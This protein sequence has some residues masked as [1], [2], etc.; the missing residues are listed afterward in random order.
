MKKLFLT[1]IGMMIFI[2]M[3]AQTNFRSITYEEGLNAAKGE[4]KLLFVDFYTT[5]CGPCKMMM[6]NVFPTK[7][8]GDYFNTN[9][10]C[11]K[12]DAEAEGK[13]LAK[14]LGVNAYPTFFVLDAT[15]NVVFK[16]VGGDADALSFIAAIKQGVN[17]ELSP[18]RMAERYASGERSAELIE[19][20]ANSLYKASREGRTIDN[21]KIEQAQKMVNDY[22]NSLTIEQKLAKENLFIYGMNYTSS[23]TD[24]KAIFMFE[25]K[26]KFVLESQ[27]VIVK[28]IK[29]L[30][31]SELR[32]Y[33][34]GDKEY[35]QTGFNA[36]KALIAK[37]GMADAQGYKAM[38][39]IIEG[40]SAGD[41]TNFFKVADKEFE[42][43]TAAQ[44]EWLLMSFENRFS[45]AG[46]EDIK[47][48]CQFMRD[49]FRT[50]E[51][52]SIYFT[53]VTLM[54]LEK[55]LEAQ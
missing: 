19:T 39:N 21:S 15:G 6:K 16:K 42:S 33:F 18:E 14:K 54:Q 31:D 1:L 4:D 29:S 45:E 30:L 2:P 43:L 3:F 28:N 46:T 32:N 34:C 13:D 5:W 47:A 26:D 7:E 12:L 40:S 9:F 38:Y 53:A 35:N 50:L 8:A 25:N 55:L 48:A 22:F 10:V 17:A 41:N 51:A 11:L 37:Q 23:V 49:H 44:K 52:S 36:L 20:Y 24:P 27:E